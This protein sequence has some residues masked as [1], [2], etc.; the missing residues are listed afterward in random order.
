[1]LKKG[2]EVFAEMITAAKKLMLILP[3]TQKRPIGQ[4][5]KLIFDELSG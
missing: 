2:K 3:T 1:M 4:V 5:F